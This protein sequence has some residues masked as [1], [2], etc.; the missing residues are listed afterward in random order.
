MPQ[1]IDSRLARSSTTQKGEPGSEV[2]LLRSKLD[3]P[4]TVAPSGA[5]RITGSPSTF[6]GPEA[7]GPCS[8]AIAIGR[9]AALPASAAEVRDARPY[10]GKNNS[11]FRVL[12]FSVLLL[13]LAAPRPLPTA[14]PDAPSRDP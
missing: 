11:T 13:P 9:P 10:D 5:A 14:R 3:V 8:I 6:F 7:D 2:E 12:R 1:R 4:L